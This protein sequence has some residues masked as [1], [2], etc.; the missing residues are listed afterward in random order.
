[1]LL[2]N[3]KQTKYFSLNTNDKTDGTKWNIP[4]NYNFSQKAKM[5]LVSINNAT[6]SNLNMV[7]CPTIKNNYFSSLNTSPLIYAGIG[8]N[9]QNIIKRIHM[10]YGGPSK[11]TNASFYKHI[12]D[13]PSLDGSFNNI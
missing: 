11:E 10:F 8:Y 6:D 1:M 3:N 7:F 9:N 4:T 12:E 13:F 5:A 2:N